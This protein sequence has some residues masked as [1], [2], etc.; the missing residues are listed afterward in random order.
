MN[1]PPAAA[2]LVPSADEATD[3]QFALG[4]LVCV[5]VAPELVEV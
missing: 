1:P 2:S 5:H 3:T 4:A